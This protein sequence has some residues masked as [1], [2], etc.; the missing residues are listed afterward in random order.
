MARYADFRYGTRRYG[1][2]PRAISRSFLLAQAVDYGKVLI[3]LE[4]E[5][6]VGFG[7][8]LTRTRTGAAEDPSNGV[9]VSSGILTAPLF[10]IMDGVDNLSDED[11]RNDVAVP[12]GMVYY[13]L[14]IFDES[15]SWFKD[16][17]TSL[18]VPREQGSHAFI[19]SLLPT[20]Y[21]SED[22]NPFGYVPDNSDL[23]RFLGGLAVTLDEWKTALGL[24]LPNQTRARGTVRRLHDA[25]VSSL[26]MPIE[27]TIGVAASSRLY[28]DAGL[29]YS[30]KGTLSGL[31]LYA[32]ALTN[33]NTVIRESTNLLLS[34]DDSSFES[35]IGFW[36]VSGGTLVAQQVDGGSV[37]SPDQE[38]EDPVSPFARGYVGRVTLSSEEATLSLPGDG[39]RLKCVSVVAGETY[40]L[41]VPNRSIE[42]E[43]SMSIGLRWLDQ[44]GSELSTTYGDVTACDT[45]WTTLSVSGEAP[46]GAH[47]VAVQVIVS[48][49]ED[50][51]VDVDMISLAESDTHFREP[52]CIDVICGPARLN[53]LA[54]PS[55]ES[56]DY[57][58]PEQGSLEYTDDEALVGLKSG[59]CEGDP[60]RIVSET[61]PVLQGFPLTFAGHTKGDGTASFVIEFLDEGDDVVS[62]QEVPAQVV[63]DSW[64]RTDEIVIPDPL[65]VTFRVVLEGEGVV[66]FDGL[67]LERADRP[68]VYFDSGVTDQTG[69]DGKV[70]TKNGNVYS[71]L[72]P[73]RLVKLIRLRQTLPFYLPLGVRARVLL[74]D[75]PDPQV[76]DLLPYGQ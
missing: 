75:S 27:S 17:A 49:G 58:V 38:F 8:A 72:Y 12:S 51:V 56:D 70:A 3:T 21:L 35:G 62:Q 7:Y 46:L 48:G 6:R 42:G 67:S 59:K 74:W 15:G 1:A 43:I 53:L 52:R 25:Y 76:E 66:Y 30:R 32:E 4:V 39:R 5:Q 57:W 29:I 65:A 16:A 60:F 73:N 50:D 13:T 18:V 45:D 19:A 37:T 33:W 31:Q 34:L 26:G 63:S 44:S 9:V 64:S 71:L 2:S 28:R 41:K 40:V 10:S 36:G 22:G 24:I 54:N 61:N 23:Y 68:L 14:F 69:E 11:V 55:F 47:F 20:A